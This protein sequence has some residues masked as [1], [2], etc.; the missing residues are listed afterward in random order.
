MTWNEM[1]EFVLQQIANFAIGLDLVES[2]ALAVARRPHALD[3]RIPID[4]VSDDSE[5]TVAR[6]HLE[7][8]RAEGVAFLR[9]V[10]RDAGQNFLITANEL[11]AAFGNALCGSDEI[12]RVERRKDPGLFFL[13]F[14]LVSG[15]HRVG[16][17]EILV[18]L[19][20]QLG[21][22]ESLAFPAVIKMHV[23][24]EDCFDI[25][26]LEADP[27]KNVDRF[28]PAGKRVLRQPMI[29]AKSAIDQGDVLLAADFTTYQQGIKHGETNCTRITEQTRPGNK[30]YRHVRLT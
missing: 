4:G 18:Q 13:G 20:I 8:L 17:S 24:H 28:L 2:V 25:F 12:L 7:P 3:V 15:T 11:Y 10:G 1:I 14:H 30:I 16:P 5:W 21:I 27:T 23:S 22:G 29:I 26:W 6:L 19:D 9:Q